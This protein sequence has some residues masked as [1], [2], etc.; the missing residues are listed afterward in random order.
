MRIDSPLAG[1]AAALLVGL[2]GGI[3]NGMGVTK[4]KLEPIIV[5]LATYSAFR[6]FALLTTG[7]YAV[8][9]KNGAFNVG[10]RIDPGHPHPRVDPARFSSP[11]S[12]S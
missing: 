3:I 5:T 12:S 4:G 11:S 7:G 1:L 2:L 8:N 6:R 10:N 9:V